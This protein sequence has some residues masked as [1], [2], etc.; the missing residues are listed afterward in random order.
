MEQVPWFGQLL[1]WV[2]RP[3]RIGRLLF[4]EAAHEG[5]LDLVHGE[6]AHR[7]PWDAA[8]T[9]HMSRTCLNCDPPDRSPRAAVPHLFICVVNTPTTEGTPLMLMMSVI[10]WSTSK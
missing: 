10:D 3:H 2:W 5:F 6:G 1:L 9:R 7:R 4:F 8:E